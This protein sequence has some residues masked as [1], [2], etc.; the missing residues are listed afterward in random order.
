MSLVAQKKTI[1]VVFRDW[2]ASRAYRAEEPLRCAGFECGRMIEV[3]ELYT[4]HKPKVAY[5]HYSQHAFCRLCIPFVE[6]D[7]SE[8]DSLREKFWKTESSMAD[9]QK[10]A[11]KEGHAPVF[12]NI[13]IVIPPLPEEQK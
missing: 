5:Y 2:V 4:K 12:G 11:G 1:P 8:I 7:G 13:R 10:W 3:G 9:D 6:S